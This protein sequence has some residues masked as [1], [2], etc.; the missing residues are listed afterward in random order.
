[1]KQII[2]QRMSKKGGFWRDCSGV[3]YKYPIRT[4][5]LLASSLTRAVVPILGYRVESLGGNAVPGF[6]SGEMN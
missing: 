1:M 4:N 2:K 6:S 5:A 3:V